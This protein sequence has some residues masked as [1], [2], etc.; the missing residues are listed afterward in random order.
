[1]ARVKTDPDLF[2]GD[3]AEKDFSPRLTSNQIRAVLAI[4]KEAQAGLEL[5]IEETDGK[6][7][8]TEATS[9]ST[10]FPFVS[11]KK[12]RT[13]TDS[14]ESSSSTRSRTS[15]SLLSSAS[16]PAAKISL[17]A[18]IKSLQA[19]P[20]EKEV[21]Q[22]LEPELFFVKQLA[23]IA[24]RLPKAILP[25]YQFFEDVYSI[26]KLL[27]DDD[28]IES[29]D[30][31]KNRLLAQDSL[32]KLIANI[33][34]HHFAIN[35]HR[36]GLQGGC[37][38]L[39]GSDLYTE[40]ES[41]LNSAALFIDNTEMLEWPLRAFMIDR[42]TRSSFA[43]L[44]GRHLQSSKVLVPTQWQFR[45]SYTRVASETRGWQ[46]AFYGSTIEGGVVYLPELNSSSSSSL[47]ITA[48]PGPRAR[49][50]WW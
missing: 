8:E 32:Q 24:N 25:R 26:R 18:K 27:K 14:R 45:A 15:A 7:V 42:S 49:P 35:N 38:I 17:L 31:V 2:T 1:M 22:Y 43:E 3:D 48:I 39:D 47:S 23:K 36:L 34:L 40:C 6:S 11:P 29:E 37:V 30:H 19:I 5:V 41:A 50:Q 28:E 10:T 46:A 16:E 33:E 9:S 13:S 44:V 20:R 21:L 12:S 4:M